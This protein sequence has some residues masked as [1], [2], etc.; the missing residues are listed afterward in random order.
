MAIFIE[1]LVIAL[2]V[3]AGMLLANV[4]WNFLK[5]KTPNI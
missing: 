1:G 2:A 3:C 5:N 4:I